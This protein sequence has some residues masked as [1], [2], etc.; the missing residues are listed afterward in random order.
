MV[1]TI[2]RRVGGIPHHVVE[3]LMRLDLARTGFIAVLAAALF[4]LFLLVAPRLTATDA[5][6]VTT[7]APPH[8]ETTLSTAPIASPRTTVTVV[9]TIPVSTTAAPAAAVVPAEWDPAGLTPANGYDGTLALVA[10]ASGSASGAAPVIDRQTAHW[11]MTVTN[12]SDGLLWGLF[13][14]VEGYGRA[15]CADRRVAPLGEV[16]CHVEGTVW[17]DGTPVVAWVN[18]WTETQQVKDMVLV[19]LV[20]A[21]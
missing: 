19:D 20:I 4:G 14:Y 12:T 8:S 7:T 10:T 2:P 5:G 6:E 21:P 9:T 13:A 3:T 16:V 18:A 15:S 11:T 17:L 1:G